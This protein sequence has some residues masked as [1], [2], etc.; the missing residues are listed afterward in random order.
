M[1]D[2]QLIDSGEEQKLE[3]FGPYVIQRPCFSAPWKPLLKKPWNLVD[4]AFSRSTD[5]KEKWSSKKSLPKSWVIDHVGVK[6]KIS[7]TDFGHLGIFPEHSIVCDQLDK[8]NL[9]GKKVLNLF[10]YTGLVSIYSALKSATV[11]HLD[12][13][14]PAVQWAKENAQ[15]NGKELSIRYITD[16]VM[17]FL[18]RENRRNSVYDGIILDPPSFGRGPK[19]QVF[20]IEKE[21]SPLMELLRPLLAKKDS[22]VVLSSHTPGY[23][24]STLTTMLE[25]LSPKADIEDY[26]MKIESEKGRSVSVGCYAVWKR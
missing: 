12:A 7:P 24:P 14:K 1:N 17:Q 25:E 11:T 3:R 20:K 22:F 21:F 19:G 10:A 13:S 26:E 18:K 9:K 16:D 15:L 5:K 6:M 23:M 8:M 2:Y 4:A